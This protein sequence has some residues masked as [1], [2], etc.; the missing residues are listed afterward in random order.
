[1]MEVYNLTNKLAKDTHKINSILKVDLEKI[2]H[3]IDSRRLGVI[4]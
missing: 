2:Q 3:K 1:M 4:L